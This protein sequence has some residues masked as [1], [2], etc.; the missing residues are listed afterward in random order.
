MSNELI[1]HTWC[2]I[3][4]RQKNENVPGIEAWV[5]AKNL[6]GLVYQLDPCQ[7]HIDQGISV[8]DIF[9]YGTEVGP[10]RIYGGSHRV[11]RPRKAASRKTTTQAA[12]PEEA[13]GVPARYVIE[14]PYCQKRFLSRATTTRAV[15]QGK[16]GSG[17]A[18]HRKMH[19]EAGVPLTQLTQVKIV[20]AVPIESDASTAADTEAE[21][22]SA[23]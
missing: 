7:P 8:D 17:W 21:P 20:S 16:H 19:L 2:D 13:V 1:R 9:T 12:E 23:G 10:V 11:R 15:E 4:L 18:L 6:D 14:C 5:V 3:C 22:V